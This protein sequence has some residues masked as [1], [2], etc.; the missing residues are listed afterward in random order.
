MQPVQAQRKIS[1]FL[2]RR[3]QQKKQTK[4]NKEL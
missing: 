2:T 3:Q 4:N 1:I